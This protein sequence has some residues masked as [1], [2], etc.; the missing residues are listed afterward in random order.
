[1]KKAEWFPVIADKVDV[2]NKELLSLVLRYVDHDTG[3]ARKYL[4]YFLECDIGITGHSL[5]DKTTTT[6]QCYCLDLTKL[7]GVRHMPKLCNIAGSV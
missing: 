4:I 2:S 5:A 7:Y 1:M 3:L 6:L